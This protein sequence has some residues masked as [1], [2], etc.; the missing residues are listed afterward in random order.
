M[1]PRACSRLGMWL[2]CVRTCWIEPSIPWPKARSPN[3]SR[4]NIIVRDSLPTAHRILGRRLACNPRDTV[5]STRGA[6]E[7]LAGA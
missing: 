6:G 1:S 4:K 5:R 3:H 7:L 2:V